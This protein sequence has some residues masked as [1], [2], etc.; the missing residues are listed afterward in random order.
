MLSLLEIDPVL[1][2]E[3]RSHKFVNQSLLCRYC[4]SLEQRRCASF[5]Q[6]LKPYQ[7][8]MFILRMVEIVEYQN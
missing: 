8:K 4:L 2:V 6:R 1:L 5:E 3:K 7:T